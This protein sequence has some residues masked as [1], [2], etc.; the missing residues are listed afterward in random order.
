MRRAHGALL[1]AGAAVVGPGCKSSSEATTTSA[2][3]ASSSASAEATASA[4]P[5]ASQSSAPRA[6]MKACKTDD[7]CVPKTCCH[8]T[9]CTLADRAPSCEKAR[10]GKK[11]D[12]TLD[13]GGK[14]VCTDGT[15]RAFTARLPRGIRDMG[16]DPF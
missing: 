14:C 8:A 1:L 3:A 4:A 11:R 13:H 6:P 9:E 15:C 7:D 12:K 10:C 2:P 5:S 16:R